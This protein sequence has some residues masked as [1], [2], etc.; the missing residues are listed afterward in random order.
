MV[1]REFGDAGKPLIVLLPGMF[2]WWRGNFGG[3]LGGLE[4]S[5]RVAVVSYSG[6]DEEEPDAAFDT[7]PNEVEQLE[8]ALHQRY[9]ERIRAVYGSSLGGLFAG[10]LMARKVMRFDRVILGSTDLEHEGPLGARLKA[11]HLA[12]TV[13]QLLHEG[14]PRSEKMRELMRH[15]LD[16]YPELGPAVL[17]ALGVG[18]RDMGFVK[19]VS[20]E[21]MLVSAL[22]TSLPRRVDVPGTEAHVLYATRMGEQYRARYLR[23]FARPTIHELDL[24]HEELLLC[25]PQR[26][27]GLVEGICR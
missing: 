1:I 7:V 17:R 6:F 11:R 9:G 26:W 23:H 24:Q 25:Q 8:R 3:V 27:L 21:H 10:L 15:Q 4:R 13:Y 19:R 20:I 12:P 16:D 5:F 22:T 14:Q 18:K 2:C